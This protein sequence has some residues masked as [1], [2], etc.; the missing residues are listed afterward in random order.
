MTPLYFVSYP[1]TATQARYPQIDREALA[2]YWGIR[3]FHLYLYGKEFTVVTD[4]QPLVSLFNNPESKPSARIE[5]WLMELQRY[6]FIVEYQPGP[7]NPAD[8]ASRHPTRSPTSEDNDIEDA[9][10]Y[11]SYITHNAI[12]KAM[13]LAEVETA[14]ANDPLLQAVMS[15]LRSGQW[16]QPPSGISC[17]ELSRF[18]LIKDELTCMDTVVLKSNRIVIPTTLQE[19]VTDIAHE[20]HQGMSKTKA[21][22]REKVWFPHMDRLVESKVKSCLACQ[23]STP[24]TSREPLQMTSLPTGPFEE[25]SIDFAHV[26]G[27]TVLLVVDDYSRYPFVEI[28]SSTAANAVIPKLDKLFATFGTP[29]TVKSDNGP[30]FNGEEFARF[31]NILGFKHRKVTPL[32]PRANGEVERFVK[33]F[34]KSVKTA[35]L[36]GRS[37]G[38][39]IQSFLRNYRTSPHSTTGVAPS[40][41]FLKRAVRSKLPQIPNHDPIGDLVRKHDTTQKLKIKAYADNK[42]YVKPSDLKVGDTV[43]VKRPFNMKANTPY[44]TLP[45]MV[46][47]KKGTMITASDGN[48]S[49]T[50]NSSFF[51]KLHYSIPMEQD[52]QM[53]SSDD[54]LEFNVPSVP[55]EPDKPQVEPEIP[56]ENPPPMSEPGSGLRRSSRVSKPPDRLNL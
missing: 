7:S 39:E 11:V 28:V 29:M 54:T 44:E 1:L 37:W 18:E 10:Q 30:P 48:R 27:K 3:R 50:R 19:R 40:T 9:D 31:A 20:G 8:Y 2:I 35:N 26:E 52:D 38:K 22:L 56:P 15:C 32:W 55:I 23:I 34:K 5:R 45:L 53:L 12:P 46:S 13:T 41:L 42:N 4:H 33:T 43:L 16:H 6:R 17:A 49:V 47:G 14:T 21:L 25:I 24:I 36:E 51:K